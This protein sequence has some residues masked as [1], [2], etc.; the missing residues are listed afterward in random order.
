MMTPTL[1]AL[2]RQLVA[3]PRWQWLRGMAVAVRLPT[4]REAWCMGR[5]T[6]VRDREISRW[7]AP[8]E[9]LTLSPGCWICFS[10]GKR[11]PYVWNRVNIW[12]ET[13]PPSK[14]LPVG[15]VFPDLSDPVTAAALLPLAREVSGCPEAVACCWRD[16]AWAVWPYSEAYAAW[17]E[18][19]GDAYVLSG[20]SGLTWTEHA[21]EIG[22]LA[23]V[24]L[25]GGE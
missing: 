25:R 23:A 22:A 16:L 1:E 2:A 14:G 24:I 13:R 8:V 10:P 12:S 6:D 7:A 18:H 17:C 11:I 20:M 9:V 5:V 19:G 15:S 21:S 3:S 4:S